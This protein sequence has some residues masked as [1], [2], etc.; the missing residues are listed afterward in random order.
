MNKE[1]K[2]LR[3]YSSGEL[4]QMALQAAKNGELGRTTFKEVNNVDFTFMQLCSR[5]NKRKIMGR[6]VL[7]NFEY[8]N[9]KEG[10]I[11][12]EIIH[13]FNDVQL[14]FERLLFEQRDEV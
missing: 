2:Q 8:S 11:K 4:I 7:N 10:C 6:R 14:R 9:I 3:E 13:I 5:L 1:R 12:N